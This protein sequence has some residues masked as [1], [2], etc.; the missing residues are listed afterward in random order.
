MSIGRYLFKGMTMKEARE[1]VPLTQG[2]VAKKLGITVRQLC[3][4]EAGQVK[5]KPYQLEVLNSLYL[6]E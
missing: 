5:L 6:N 3:R 4:W 1:S 2:F